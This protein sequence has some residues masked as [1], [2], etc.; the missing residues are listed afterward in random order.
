MEVKVCH[1]FC[2]KNSSV[3]FSIYRGI[4]TVKTIHEMKVLFCLILIALS[5]WENKQTNKKGR[6]N[7]NE[8]LYLKAL[9]EGQLNS[10]VFF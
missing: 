1:A 7:V 6:K 2:K 4:E 5:L 9:Y 8:W 10:T 3:F